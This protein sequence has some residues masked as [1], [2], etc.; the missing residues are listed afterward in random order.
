MESCFQGLS[1][2]YYLDSKTQDSEQFKGD[3]MTLRVENM[4]LIFACN[5]AISSL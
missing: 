3:F 2:R 1:F 5:G 4:A